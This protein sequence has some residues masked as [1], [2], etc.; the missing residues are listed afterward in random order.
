MRSCNN[1]EFFFF[2]I[3]EKDRNKD[4]SKGYFPV[5]TPFRL[6]QAESCPEYRD[7]KIQEAIRRLTPNVQHVERSVDA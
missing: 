7:W 6:R 5:G 4:C 1:C 2:H 3:L